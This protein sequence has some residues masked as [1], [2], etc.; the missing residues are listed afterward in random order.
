LRVIEEVTFLNCQGFAVTDLTGLEAFTN[1]ESLTLRN[2]Q[3]T[4]LSAVLDLPALQF[5]D[6]EGLILE[7]AG[8]LDALRERG[9]DVQ[10]N[11][12]VLLSSLTFADP[13]LEAC[14]QQEVSFNGQ[15]L[16]SELTFLSCF[17]SVLADLSGIGQLTSLGFLELGF[18]SVVDFSPVTQ[19]PNLGQLNILG[20]TFTD[21]SLSQVV[22][23]PTLRTLSLDSTS[24]TDLSLLVPSAN[25]SNLFLSFMNIDISPLAEL[26][27]LR[28]LALSNSFPTNFLD[29]ANLTQLT[30]LSVFNGPLQAEQIDIIYQLSNLRRLDIQ[31][32]LPLDNSSLLELVNALPNLESLNLS[33][34]QV[35]NLNA[36]TG[37]ASLNDVVLNRTP[38]EDIS[39]LFVGGDIANAPI[40]SL[41]FIDITG[42]PVFS[43]TSDLVAQVDAL[44]SNPQVFVSGELTFGELISDFVG[45]LSDE[46][47]GA[48]IINNSSGLVVTGQIR[49]LSCG[50]TTVSDLSG[51]ELLS[52]L[53][54]IFIE[55]TNV[56]DLTPILALPNLVNVGIENLTLDD[57]GQIDVLR[58]R[59]VTV[60]D[61]QDSIPVD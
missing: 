55:N 18:T 36:V 17:D 53:E 52:N 44:R 45:S 47:L 3:V 20:T 61:N 19:I 54:N 7:D 31:R 29:V 11:L 14:I 1:L 35:T 16:V 60:F 43:D 40:P 25:L 56:T 46:A 57:P 58:N 30:N 24:V 6:V 5:I 27:L 13:A 9:I 8:Q 48:C 26:P 32:A 12:G 59:G 21:E 33:D 37:L 10:G 23:I 49:F 2:T 34:S 42:V 22:T 51:V 38:I 4:N 15:E 28:N 50:F 41:R 39:A